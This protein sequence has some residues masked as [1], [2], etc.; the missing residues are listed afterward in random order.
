VTFDSAP[1]GKGDSCAASDESDSSAGTAGNG[2][3]T[4]RYF[5]CSIGLKFLITCS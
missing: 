2:A 3:E 5:C 1:L 4:L